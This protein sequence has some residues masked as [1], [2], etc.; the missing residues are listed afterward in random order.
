MCCFAACACSDKNIWENLQKRFS[1]EQPPLDHMQDV[2][3]GREYKKHGEF[4]SRKA[5]VSLT[6]NT[7]GTDVFRSSTVSM[8]PIW[9][10]INELPPLV[11]YIS[12]LKI[13]KIVYSILI[14]RFSKRNLL[15]GGLWF[16]KAKPTMST[17][18]HP[19]V[20]EINLLAN[21]GIHAWW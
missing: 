19:I 9:L 8:Y 10:T 3:N 2:L 18:L 11:R 17:F 5:N 16:S 14:C 21:K 12:S 7:D 20:D 4:L 6:I 15:L 13:K 1:R